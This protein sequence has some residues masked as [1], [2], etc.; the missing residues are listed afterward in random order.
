MP[1]M[2]VLYTTRPL[3]GHQHTY[4]KSSVN[5]YDQVVTLP[6]LP[7]C[8]WAHLEHTNIPNTLFHLQHARS[9]SILSHILQGNNCG[10]TETV[11]IGRH[12]HLKS[13]PQYSQPS[14][15]ASFPIVRYKHKSHN[16]AC[17]FAQ[18]KTRYS[19]FN[20]D[21]QICQEVQPG[22]TTRRTL[23]ES[24]RKFSSQCDRNLKSTV[25]NVH[26]CSWPQVPSQLQS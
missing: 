9:T 4:K 11:T 15:R 5:P 7:R 19:N 6:H 13:L 22:N 8:V 23:S 16:R 2:I 3:S 25:V 24:P 1:E 20:V 12:S 17:R 14:W 10:G 26:V 18:I 21:P